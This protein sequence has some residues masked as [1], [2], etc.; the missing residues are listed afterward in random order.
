MSAETLTCSYS[1]EGSAG[2]VREGAAIEEGNDPT[3]TI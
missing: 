3:E 2:I 1:H